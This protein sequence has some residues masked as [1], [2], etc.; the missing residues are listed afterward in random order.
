VRRL[1]RLTEEE[2]YFRC[3]G[4]HHDTVRVLT[5]EPRRPRDRARMSG[6][7]LRREFEERL[8][9]RGPETELAA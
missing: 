9:V 6:E 2:C 7:E 3:Y 1:R 5:L 4:D 8:D